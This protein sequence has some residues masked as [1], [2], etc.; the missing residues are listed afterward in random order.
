MF[1]GWIKI[2]NSSF[3]DSSWTDVNNLT[4]KVIF[5]IDVREYGG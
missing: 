2:H 3:H 4:R 1:Y 5:Y